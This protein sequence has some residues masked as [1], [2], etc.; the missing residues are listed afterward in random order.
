MSREGEVVVQFAVAGFGTDE[1]FERRC[2]IEKLLDA[3]LRKARNGSCTGG[4]SGSDTMN[5][6]LSVKDAGRA[7]HT[8]LTALRQDGQ[9]EDVIVA[10]G[11][12][13]GGERKGYEV[14][15]PEG[16]RGRFSPF[17]TVRE[18]E[19]APPLRPEQ[20]KELKKFQGLWRL[21]RYESFDG[22]PVPEDKFASLRFTFE[23]NRMTVRDR[24]YK[25]SEATL[26]L[27]PARSP[28]AVDVVPTVGPNRGRASRGIYRLAKGSCGCVPPRWGRSARPPS[29]GRRGARWGSWCC[30]AREARREGRPPLSRRP[31]RGG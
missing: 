22:S 8:I 19:P 30:G 28:K 7:K 10:H 2:H 25:V 15:W 14:W 29:T 3:A 16:F 17:G 23:G 12:E 21:V 18:D 6:F 20:Q 11:L 9:L 13:E 31:G 27:D 5:V 26:D 4:D 1:D 24:G